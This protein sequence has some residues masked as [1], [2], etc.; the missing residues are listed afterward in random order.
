[1]NIKSIEN[2]KMEEQSDKNNKL[3]VRFSDD[4]KKTIF[5][6]KNVMNNKKTNKKTNK[7]S[8]MSPI[9]LET[10]DQNI[11]KTN[12]S[13]V[14]GFTKTNDVNQYDIDSL[15][16]DDSEDN[17]NLDTYIVLSFNDIIQSIPKNS[18]KIQNPD[19]W[20]THTEWRWRFFDLNGRKLIEISKLPQSS[21]SGYPTKRLYMDNTGKWSESTLKGYWDQFLVDSWFYYVQ[22]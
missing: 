5:S 9:V 16:D 3:T 4:T 20:I 14:H 13:L 17:T 12:N 21:A 2:C 11:P 18:V 6:N 8:Q 10:N 19:L 1:M 15:T 22:E 7:I